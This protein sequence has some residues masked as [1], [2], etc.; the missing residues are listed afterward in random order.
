M[1]CP[2]TGRSLLEPSPALARPTVGGRFRIDE[3]LGVG[4]TGVVYA[5]RDLL[6]G[7]DVAVKIFRSATPASLEWRR[8]ER[9]AKALVGLEHPNLVELLETGITAGGQPYVALERLVGISLERHLAQGRRVALPAAASMLERLLSA[10]SAMHAVGVVHRDISPSNV[11]LVEGHARVKLLDSGFGRVA[12]SGSAATGD[13]SC[14]PWYLAPEQL[15]VSAPDRPADVYGLGAVLYEAITGVPPF[16]LPPGATI[17]AAVRLVLTHEPR[18][19]SQLREDL[20]PT[21]EAFLLRAIARD[22]A[23]RFQDAEEMR[24][25][26]TPALAEMRA[27][28]PAGSSDAH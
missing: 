14:R 26:A 16:D 5:A 28:A 15:L 9:E 27:S 22:R 24:E 23:D 13:T 8:F 21:V 17:A 19:P 1:R 7:R 12:D 25:A 11:F 2:L 4:S 10:L 20:P 18:P 6:A 3:L